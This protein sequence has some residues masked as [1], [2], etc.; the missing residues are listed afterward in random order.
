MNL[1]I[2]ICACFLSGCASY[3]SKFICKEASGNPCVMLNSVDKQIAN[4]ESA[5]RCC[6]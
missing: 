6:R 3:N 1:L 4:M 2:L 5:E